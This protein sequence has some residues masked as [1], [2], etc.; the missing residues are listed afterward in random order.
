MDDLAGLIGTIILFFLLFA[1][2]NLP[3]WGLLHVIF[4]V[5][6]GYWK[7]FGILVCGDIL[8]TV[9]LKFFT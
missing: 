5:T 1:L 6:C 9:I 3:F 4:H 2:V 8:S 7:S